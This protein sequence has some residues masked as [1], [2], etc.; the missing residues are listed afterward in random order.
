MCATCVKHADTGRLQGPCNRLRSRLLE[1]IM[2]TI[3]I[4]T[5]INVIDYYCDYIV[6]ESRIQS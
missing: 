6:Q 1:I 3:M 4:T 2:I 5:F